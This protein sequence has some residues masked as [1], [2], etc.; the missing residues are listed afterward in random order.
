MVVNCTFLG[1]T[2]RNGGGAIHGGVSKATFLNCRF[3]GNTAGTHGGA[4]YADGG[5]PSLVNCTISGHTAVGNGGAIF[6]TSS[7]ALKLTNCTV[8]GNASTGSYG[9]SGGLNA[10]NGTVSVANCIFWGNRDR[11]GA[12]EVAQIHRQTGC[13]LTLTHSCVQF[14]SG[15]L[16]GTAVSGDDPRLADPD[17]LDDV[18]GTLDDDL[19]LL[20]S[21]VGI[22]AGSND[23]APADAADLDADGDLLEPV[24]L[25]LGGGPRFD[26]ETAVED[27]GR[28]TPPIV[29]MGAYEGGLQ[30][31]VLSTRTLSIP[32]GGSATFTVV[33]AKDPGGSLQANVAMESDDPDITLTSGNSLTFT[34]ADY[35]VPRTVTLAAAA[36]V[37]NLC[38][39]ATIAV[40]GDGLPT[41][42]L[43]AKESDDEPVPN[44]L[45][46][47]PD[48][49]GMNN[50]ADWA[51]AYSDL[52]IAMEFAAAN[53]NVHEIRIAQGVYRPAAAPGNRAATFQL[54]NGLALRGGYAGYGAPDPDRRDPRLH[55]STLSGDLAGDDLPGFFNN[56][57]NA[58]H[59]VTTS[60][61][62]STAVLD[63][64]TIAAGNAGGASTA[65]GGGLLNVGGTPTI[66]G[67][68]FLRNE[69]A[70]GGGLY[71]QG[72]A[73]LIDGC[74]FLG[75]TAT[76]NG[77]G[78]ALSTGTSGTTLVNCEFS[79]NA[80]EAGG[81]AYMSDYGLLVVN[82]TFSRNIAYWGTGGLQANGD[83]DTRNSIYWQN[84][85]DGNQ[86]PWAQVEGASISTCCVQNWDPDEYGEGATGADPLLVD[87]D[88]PDNIVGTADDDLRLGAPS[89]CIDAGDNE[90]VPAGI[91]T[92][93]AGGPRFRDVPGVPD[94]GYG[95]P[96]LVD[97]GPYE[98][99][100]F[101]IADLDLD[102]DVDA[103]D[104][105]IWEPCAN[106]P[107]QPL[108]ADPGCDRAD[109]DGD[110]DA[111]AA[112]FA[113]LQRCYGT[114]ARPPAASCGG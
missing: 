94:T 90:S 57:E 4:L 74:R 20:A 49:P 77:G 43:V 12:T 83:T 89:P 62:D 79:G 112:D 58:W 11:S 19:R 61:T 15:S 99:G 48:A 91:T 101:W 10:Y 23:Q 54:R 47:D 35:A 31:L 8:A 72:S 110:D 86:A 108:A 9:N 14:W 56:G 68:T 64:M 59:V 78:L 105:L 2:A 16:G 100:S 30:A 84:T 38:G 111:D 3:L 1:N 32:E 92:D 29:D 65:N 53:T 40:S 36:D 22:D 44:V 69:A 67:C 21:S 17:G 51:G 52:L 41:E 34:S 42:T 7:A 96:P 63:S 95:D 76:G 28:G 46:V 71:S 13:T 45:Y 106:G 18:A 37:D 27:R 25:D 109:F 60:G 80:G 88:G 50:G 103:A 97:L 87:P 75:N 24:P 114:T 81:G 102:G 70:S 113:L 39:Q 98:Y 82:C 66:R 93:L 73:L 26:D 5:S 6:S 85:G 33:L 107:G 55:P 104:R